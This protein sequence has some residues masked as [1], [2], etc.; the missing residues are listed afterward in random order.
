MPREGFQ[1]LHGAE[2]VAVY[3]P[4][5]GDTVKAFCSVCGSSLF[6]RHWPDGDVLA[7]R[8]GAFDGNAGISPQFHQWVGTKAPWEILPD[9]GLPRYDGAAPAD[10]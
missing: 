8:L 3:A 9:D 5:E 2:L 10:A 6:G 7:I 1:L 4:P